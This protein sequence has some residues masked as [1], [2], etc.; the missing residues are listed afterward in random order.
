[1]YQRC[2]KIAKEMYWMLHDIHSQC[3]C[4]EIDYNW[5]YGAR[6]VHIFRDNATPFVVTGMTLQLKNG[7]QILVAPVV[8]NASINNPDS[9]GWFSLSECHIPI[10]HNKKNFTTRS[11]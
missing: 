1:M 6:V 4:K 5:L 2:Y 11:E 10:K 9:E 7:K 8:P 3:M